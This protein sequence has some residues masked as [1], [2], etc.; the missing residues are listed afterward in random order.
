MSSSVS[1]PVSIHGVS[2]KPIVSAL[3]ATLPPARQGEAASFVAAFYARLE[4][5]EFTTRDAA[6]WAALAGGFLEFARVRPAGEMRVRVFNP[7]LEEHG[8]D[9]QHTA[10]QIVNDDMPFLVDSVTMALTQADA[11]IYVLGHPVTQ[12]TRDAAGSIVAVGEGK[13]ESLMHIEFDRQLEVADL[14]RIAAKVRAAIE[15]VRS[16]FLDWRAMRERVLQI[17]AELPGR[18]MPVSAEG[19]Q[20]AQD[21]LRW[22]ADDHFTFLGFREYEVVGA[23][24]DELLRAV[25]DTGLGLLKRDDRAGKP[26][27]LKTLAAH[28]MPQSGS[29]DALIIT[30]TN[31]RS[32]VHRPGYMDYIGV[33]RFDNTGRAIGEQRF[34]GLFTSSAYN[35]RPWDIPLVRHRFEYVMR[36][37]GLAFNSHSGKALRHI[38]ETLPRDE[39]FQSTEDEL[40]QTCLGI[41]GLQERVRS[42]LF[43]RRDRYGRFYSVLAYIPRD[44]FNTENRLRIEALLMETLN[45]QRIDTTI[46]V[47]ESPLAQLHLIVRP[48][49]GDPGVPDMDML[50]QRLSQIVR[51]WHDDL[52]DLLV[53]RHGEA[54]GLRLANRFGKALPHSYIEQISAEVAADDVGD[55]AAL[56]DADDLRLRMYRAPGAAGDIRLKLFRRDHGTPLSDVLPMMEAMGLRILSEHPYELSVDGA[57]IVIQDFVIRAQH[58][59]IDVEQVREHFEHAFKQLWHGQSEVD[60]FMR[61]VLTA[62]LDWRQV[63][64][65][66]AYCKYLL[67]TGVAFSQ[68]YMEQTLA[69]YPLAARLLAELFESRFDPAHD[70]PEAGC[71]DAARQALATALGSI[72]SPDQHAAAATLIEQVSYAR[73]LD[74]DA[75]IDACHDALEILLDQVSS[76][77]EDRILRRFMA[78]IDATLRTNFHQ[79]TTGEY[80]P[81]ISLKFDP[82][83]VPDL[84]RPRPYREIFVCAPQVEGVHLRF[85]PVARGGLRW[86]DRREDFR[87]EVLGLVKAQMVKNTVIV[88]V[89]AKG[90]FFVK[91]PPAGGDRDAVL[92]EGIACY[93]MFINGLLDIT[94]NLVDGELVHPHDVVRHDGD[95][96]YLVVAADKGTATFS[97]IANAIAL[98]RGFWLGDAFASGGS[99]GYDHKGMG[100]TARGAWESVKRHFRALGVDCQNEDFTCVGVGDMSGDVFGNGMLLS[101]HIRLLA[102]FDHR[103]IFI[104]PAPDAARSFIERERLFKLPRSSWDD[105]DRSLISAGGGIYP[106]SL[107]TINLGAELKQ[108]L[109]IDAEITKMS[110]AELMN[111]ILQAPVDLFWNGGIGTYIKA[112]SESHDDVGDRTNNP[113]RVDGN[114]L[115]CRVVG[116]GGN[117]GLTQRGRIEAAMSGVLLNTDFIDNS[118]GVDTSD[119]EV[120]IKI[121]LDDA[122]K[123]GELNTEQRNTLLA[124]MTDEVGALVLNDNYR[125]NQAISVMERMSVARL[126]SKAHFMRTLE[127]K[128]LLDRA[129]EYLPTDA[130]LTQRK[131]R[132]QGLTRPELSVLLSYAKIVIFQQMLD[133]DVP[134]DPY[135]SKELLRYFPQ[136]LQDRFAEQMQRHR[137]R[138]EI[139]ATAVTNSLVNRMGSTFMLRMKEDTGENAAEVAKAYTITREVLDSRALWAAI[140]ELDMK[141]PESAQIDALQRIWVLQRALTRWF[142]ARPGQLGQIAAMVERYQPGMDALR[143]ALPAVLDESAAERFEADRAQWQEQGFPE[144]L[145]TSLAGLPLLNASLDIIDCASHCNRSVEDVATVFFA[146][147][148]GL[149]LNW[150]LGRVD[151]L[152]VEGRWHANARG[153]LRDELQDRQSALAERILAVADPAVGARELVEAWL[154]RDDPALTGTRAVLDELRAQRSMDFP[155]IS[156]AARRLGQLVQGSAS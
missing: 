129:L 136:P 144:A 152:P 15:D 153:V 81:Y 80:A 10:L 30:K 97:D 18:E 41:L 5:E 47:G 64:M 33:L 82:A 85:G 51:N 78:V 31:A 119:H 146:L 22:V 59:E 107:K 103:H 93:Q 37:S 128:G 2:L 138:R 137:L 73:G 35:R 142:L 83:K 96:P 17:A 114:A 154:N 147:G 87:T 60:G 42:R 72:L 58:G 49:A 56:G 130:D 57:I 94:D 25:P 77:D 121:L 92:K 116:E 6:S 149:H 150:L 26:R 102:A 123:S 100:I 7:S 156:V 63:A 53:S 110:P 11:S 135:L 27:S 14:E 124:S 90:G 12:I 45:G 54:H 91:R 55:L 126:G 148:E 132:G 46:Q 32:T 104:D 140:D 44:R 69:R 48:K 21:L 29:V 89:G 101:R 71:A 28:H 99:V 3:Q 50:E 115:R 1:A 70:C 98:E 23:G 9:S 122:V 120:N 76:I 106:R 16:C 151:E 4:Q 19:R 131:A 112:S 65:L 139:I 111:A 117:L 62:G 84:P 127:S 52:R 118:A 24:E 36:R 133:S 34:L 134:E 66:R 40:F 39:L 75:Q 43:L 143:A 145:A 141:V 105:Y 68:A 88:P 79:K 95:D 108:V 61:L 20:E 86:S 8:W 155:T 13:L 74:R 109:G 113:L 125:Q 67:Q 38:L